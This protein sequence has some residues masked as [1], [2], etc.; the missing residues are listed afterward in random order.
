[1]YSFEKGLLGGYDYL[2]VNASQ[3]DLIYGLF[4]SLAMD[5]E[6]GELNKL[7]IGIQETKTGGRD[8]FEWA[9]ED[10]H[11]VSL[12]PPA[13]VYFFDLLS[14]RHRQAEHSGP[15]SQMEHEKF[16]KFLIDFREFIEQNT[17]K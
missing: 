5:W 11:V 2:I 6:S 4:S 17:K 8:R 12:A 16:L 1:M 3:E 7:I 14:R 15:D 13:E 10:V 9:N